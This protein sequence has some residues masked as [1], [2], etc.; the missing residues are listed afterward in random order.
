MAFFPACNERQN[1][2][3][4]QP[5]CPPK[6]S[7][8]P[9]RLH[10]QP[11]PPHKQKCQHSSPYLHTI[12]NKTV[13]HQPGPH[14]RLTVVPLHVMFARSGGVTTKTKYL[15]SHLRLLAAAP[16]ANLTL[17]ITH[18]TSRITHHSS[19]TSVLFPCCCY[20]QQLLPSLA[21]GR[22]IRRAFAPSLPGATTKRGG[23]R[24]PT[25]LAVQDLYYCSTTTC[26]TTIAV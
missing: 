16:T 3:I 8:R 20:P 25:T 26:N 11:Q 9:T 15:V 4:A 22:I 24:S 1:R 10:T 13:T 23:K 14:R 6:K 21:G 17:H 5:Q 18:R 12:L 19:H 7:T 2:R